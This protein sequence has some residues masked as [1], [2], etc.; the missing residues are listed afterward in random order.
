MAVAF[1]AIFFPQPLTIFDG[2]SLFPALSRGLQPQGLPRHLPMRTSAP[3]SRAGCNIISCFLLRQRPAF[4]PHPRASCSKFKSENA[5]DRAGP[6]LR[7]LVRVV[8]GCLPGIT[9]TPALHSALSCGLQHRFCAACATP[10]AFTS[11]SRAGCN[12]KYAQEVWSVHGLVC[13]P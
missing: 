12:G 13:A 5:N 6:S 10:G 3:H 9:L 2:T 4:S 1:A 7:I 11:H 8:T